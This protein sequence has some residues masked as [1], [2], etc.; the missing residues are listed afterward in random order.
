MIR[1]ILI[2]F[3]LIVFSCQHSDTIDRQKDLDLAY[4]SIDFSS[5]D[6]IKNKILGS[7][8]GRKSVLTRDSAKGEFAV[9]ITYDEEDYFTFTETKIEKDRQAYK[10]VS[11]VMLY[12]LDNAFVFETEDKNLLNL[13]FLSEKQLKLNDTIFERLNEK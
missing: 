2:F 9:E 6:Q 10:T 5:F 7:W 3:S 12:E 8:A 4:P 13:H 1:A 11:R